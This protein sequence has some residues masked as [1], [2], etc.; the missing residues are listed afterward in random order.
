MSFLY[1][2]NINLLPTKVCLVTAM[3]FPVVMYGCES[4]T[5]KKAE[6]WRTDGFELWCWRR[7]LSVPWTARRFNQSILKEISPEYSFKG[8][9]LKLKLQ[10]FDHLMRR[11]DSLETTLMLGGIEGGRRGRQRMRSLSGITHWMN[12]SL[13]KLWDLVMDR[14][15]WC[16]VVHGVAKSQ[17]RLSDWNELNHMYDLHIFCLIPY[18]AFSFCRSFLLLCG[19]FFLWF[20]PVWVFFLLLLM[21]FMPLRSYPE[22]SLSRAV[23]RSI[24]GASLV[25]QWLRL[26][27]A[28]QGVWVHSLVG[29]LRW[30]N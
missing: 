11:M 4:L 13:S 14:K 9:R 2:L 12:M 8:L 15:A 5:V 18:V 21:L 29:E 19:R 20:S 10:S 24:S 26:H 16:A 30:E 3:V 23:S 27:L 7:L 1:I 28:L 17:T 25:V 22:K 6:C